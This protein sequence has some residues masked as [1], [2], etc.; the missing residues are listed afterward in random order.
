MQLG[1]RPVC[2]KRAS[3][4]EIP[5]DFDGDRIIC[6][7]PFE[8]TTIEC[9]ECSRNEIQVGSIRICPK[10][11]FYTRLTARSKAILANAWYSYKQS[12]KLAA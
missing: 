11:V 8:D 10:C 9:P 4:E 5:I 7:L 3:Y 1:N 2:L 12:L 6:A